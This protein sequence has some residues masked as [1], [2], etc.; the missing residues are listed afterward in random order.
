LYTPFDTV[1]YQFVLDEDTDYESFEQFLILTNGIPPLHFVCTY[2]PSIRM[3][4][5]LKYLA[6]FIP[7]GR[8]LVHNGLLP[9]HCA[10][11]SGAPKDVLEW[12]LK[13][14]P[15]LA[16]TPV[17]ETNDYPLHC[18][19]SHIPQPESTMAELDLEE[20]QEYEQEYLSTVEYLVKAHPAAVRIANRGGWIPLH[21]AAM[22]DAPLS[23]VFY[24]ARQHP[25]CMIPVVREGARKRTA[26]CLEN[27]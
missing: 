3:L 8:L 7:D 5:F 1:L 14:Y 19:V 4:E 12:W 18:Y 10:C 9:F 17:Q 13:Q 24:L 20:K 23:A 21:L 6:P 26:S 11:R 27:P 22:H 2:S 25:E 16:G 15:H